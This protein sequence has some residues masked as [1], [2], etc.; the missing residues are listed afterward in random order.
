[1]IKMSRSMDTYLPS[2]LFGERKREQEWKKEK[3]REIKL[4]LNWIP[5]VQHLK[6]QILHSNF[7]TH[8]NDTNT[9]WVC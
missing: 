7:T 5:I 3:D 8:V 1:M 2:E 9:L 4:I 6:F